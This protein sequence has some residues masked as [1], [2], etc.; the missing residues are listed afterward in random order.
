MVN[1]PLTR[2]FTS[3]DK[4]TDPRKEWWQKALNVLSGARVTDV[5]TEKQRAVETRAALEDIMRSHPT[6]SEFTNFYVKPEDTAKLTGEEIEMMRKYTELQDRAK[7]Y[8]KSKRGQI[9]IQ[10]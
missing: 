8:A 3:A 6:L 4:L 1:S 9:G 2:F 10:Q 5:D 7:K